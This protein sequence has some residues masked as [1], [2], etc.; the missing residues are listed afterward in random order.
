MG[1]SRKNDANPPFLNGEVAIHLSHNESERQWL[2]ASRVK[3]V[4][5]QSLEWLINWLFGSTTP[6]ATEEHS[7]V[8]GVD[9]GEDAPEKR[10]Q[11][12]LQ[13]P[14]FRLPGEVRALIYRYYLNLT[15]DDVR[16]S[17][18]RPDATR[19]LAAHHF[20]KDLPTAAVPGMMVACKRLYHELSPRA[21]DETTLVVWHRQWRPFVGQVF[22]YGLA[23]HG[24]LRFENLRK[25]AIR[26]KSDI[27]IGW[28][29][30]S[31]FQD[32]FLQME[33]LRELELDVFD[34]PR[35]KR[36]RRKWQQE[37]EEALAPCL[38]KMKALHTIRFR[39][40]VPSELVAF[41]RAQTGANVITS[42]LTMAWGLRGES[43]TDATGI[44]GRAR[45][46]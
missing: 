25:L 44:T 26:L 1:V 16:I 36:D 10:I 19:L 46:A 45:H 32:L 8:D 4:L 18:S 15:W 20:T 2:M 3:G 28:M 43:P 7:A 27:M 37:D 17:C 12:Q 14:L 29:W 41:F 40:A 9:Y 39:G 30:G 21:A 35:T 38:E 24:R 11:P 13:S 31:L 6:R 42:D 34:E 33:Q 23:S 5:L 22:V